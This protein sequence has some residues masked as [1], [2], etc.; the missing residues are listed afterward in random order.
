MIIKRNRDPRRSWPKKI[1][2]RNTPVIGERRERTIVRRNAG[3]GV[4]PPSGGGNGGGGNG[5]GG[6]FPHIRKR[7]LV[8]ASTVAVMG[9]VLAGGVWVYQSP[10]FEVTHI[11]VKGNQAISTDSV[12]TAANVLGESMF[13]ADLASA[14]RALYGLPLVSSVKID[15]S[16]PHSLTITVQ[17][18]QPWGTWQ[19]DGVSY[20]IDREGVILGTN[21]AP[22]GSPVIVSAEPGSHV[23]GDR[24]DYQAVTAAAEIYEKLPGQLG[25]TVTNVAFLPGKGVQ[26][27]T[28]DN[29]TAL[30][31]DSS[32]IPYKLAVWAAVAK[33][34]ANQKL[35]YTTIDLRYGNRPVLQ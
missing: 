14:Q 30:L 22:A 31:G 2:K 35:N 1:V 17:E 34:A 7:W 10:F 12:V 6:W 26:V 23:Q 18:R 5:M 13:N 8:L 9:S 16:W 15:R 4:Q 25:T 33:Q 19:Q 32:S 24:V 20:T 29:Q 11:T 28:A 27:T 21:P 3:G